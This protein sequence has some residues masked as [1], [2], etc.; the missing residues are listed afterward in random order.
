M[1]QLLAML[2]VPLIRIVKD[3]LVSIKPDIII[4][5]FVI[6]ASSSRVKWYAG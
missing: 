6:V 2:W 3:Y 4:R 1:R 5:P